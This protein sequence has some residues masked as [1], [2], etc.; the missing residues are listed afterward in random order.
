LA[1]SNNP[2]PIDNQ[3]WF[4]DDKKG[5]LIV[6]EFRDVHHNYQGCDQFIIPWRKIE[7]ARKR[8][9]KP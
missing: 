3:T 7:A 1:L 5:L 8:R 4:Y 9:A 2:Q 6:H